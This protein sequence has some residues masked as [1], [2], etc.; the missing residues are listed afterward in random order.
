MSKSDSTAFGL[1]LAGYSSG[2][3][4]FARADRQTDKKIFITIYQNNLFC[5]HLKGRERLPDIAEHERQVIESCLDRACL[6]VDVPIDLQGLP[7]VNPVHFK[8]EL[9]LRPVDFAFSALPP[10]ADRIGAPVARFINWITKIQKNATLLGQTLWETYPSASLQLLNLRSTGYKGK[11]AIFEANEW[12]AAHPGHQP[13]ANIINELDWLCEE[14]LK[15]T[16]DEFDAA[17]CALTGVADAR[18]RVQGDRL[19][20]VILNRISRGT[21]KA[22]R[23]HIRAT[24]AQGYVLLELPPMEPVY[25]C[26][27]QPRTLEETLREVAQ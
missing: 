25:V 10:L 24:P 14:G 23:D 12:R 20:E 9:T 15:L 3:S 11:S 22:H 1:D 4:G 7:N 26:V 6:V 2:K 21:E 18:A 27:K 16:D 13:L 5:R 19:E 17:L 8:W